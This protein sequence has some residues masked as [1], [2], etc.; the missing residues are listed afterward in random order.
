MLFI[1]IGSFDSATTVERKLAQRPL[2][3]DMGFRVPILER[4]EMAISCHVEGS[5][6]GKTN[7]SMGF[8]ILEDECRRCMIQR[9]RAKCCSLEV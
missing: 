5:D 8:D 1:C 7:A 2:R 4:A 9:S 3:T 6:P